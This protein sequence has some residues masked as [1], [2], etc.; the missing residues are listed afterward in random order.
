MTYDQLVNLS[1]SVAAFISAV[2]TLLTVRQMAKQRQTSYRPELVLSSTHFEGRAE[3]AGQLPLRWVTRAPQPDAENTSRELSIPL[4]NVGLGAAKGVSI[5]WSFP[6]EATVEEVNSLAQKALI[7][8]YFALQAGGLSM[9]SERFSQTTS[10]WRNQQNISIDFVLPAAVLK[11]PF[12]LKL[13]HAYIQLCSSLLYF[14]AHIENRKSSPKFPSLTANLKYQ[15][16]GGAQHQI[17]LEVTIDLV[18]FS[19]NGE[20]MWGTVQC[21]SAQIKR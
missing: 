9:T 2:A 19:G 3:V 20:K 8:A 4:H 18:S 5:A 14:S 21:R 10:M 1:A 17:R 6:I 13:P 15:D 11:D 7:P 16:I 12:A